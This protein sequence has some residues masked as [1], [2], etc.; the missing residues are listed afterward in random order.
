MALRPRAVWLLRLAVV[1]TALLALVPFGRLVAD[2]VEYARV[3][4]VPLEP[5]PP[6]GFDWVRWEDRDGE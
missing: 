3:V 6:R 2:W 5:L 4:R 1:V